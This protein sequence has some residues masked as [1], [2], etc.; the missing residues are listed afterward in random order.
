MN[1]SN[2]GDKLTQK[3]KENLNKESNLPYDLCNL[4]KADLEMKEKFRIFKNQY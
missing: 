1:S 3:L 2:K 4:L